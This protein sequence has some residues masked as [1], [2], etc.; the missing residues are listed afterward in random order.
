MS[1]GSSRGM[2]TAGTQSKRLKS[3][4]G[5]PVLMARTVRRRSPQLRT[6]VAEARG[7]ACGSCRSLSSKTRRTV[8]KRLALEQQVAPQIE[9]HRLPFSQCGINVQ[10]VTCRRCA[11]RAGVGDRFRRARRRVW[12]RNEGRVPDH[13]DPALGACAAQPNPGL[14][15]RMAPGCP[16]QGQKRRT[17]QSFGDGV[18]PLDQ[19]RLHPA[20]RDQR[21][22][23]C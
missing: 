22:N 12:P 1:P 18:L 2:K 7:R 16:L 23:R 6:R 8:P 11:Q 10:L 5:A 13:R 19:L 4:P 9:L 15:A 21:A 14:V 20:R 17:E 3:K